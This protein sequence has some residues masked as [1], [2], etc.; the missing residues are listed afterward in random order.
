M[1]YWKH[2][3]LLAFQE[4]R[5]R[6]LLSTAVNCTRFYRDLYKNQDIEKVG[7]ENI[8]DLP[9]VSKDAIR[10]T[11]PED[12]VI[13]QTQPIKEFFTSG[14][15]GKPFAVAMDKESLSE[16]RALM[17]LR[18]MYSGW[19]IG[20]PY[21]QTGMSPER[22]SLRA[23]KDVLLRVEYQ[24]AFD[25]SSE[26]LS[27][28]AL[29]IVKKKLKYVMG[30][31]GS[32]YYLAK[33]F[34]DLDIHWPLNGVVTWGDNLS[35]HQR[36]EIEG[37]FAVRVTDT[38]GC[39]E[40]I[41]VAA[42]CKHGR[43]HTFMPHVVVE[44]VDASGNPVQPGQ[45]GRILLTRL[46]AGAMPFVRYAVGDLG[47]IETEKSCRC[48]RQG[49]AIRSINGRDTDVVKTRSGNRLIVHFFTG[50]FEYYSTIAQFRIKQESLDEIHIDL[51]PAGEFDSSILGTIEQEI[52]EKAK[53]R[54]RV[55]FKIVESISVG[56]TGKIRL[57]E[58]VLE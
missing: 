13:K 11:Y 6:M 15:S 45:I 37:R 30:F 42:Q 17:F 5:L 3:D 12:C 25:L 26:A 16:A 34:Q 9:V 7:I 46:G 55:R 40:G 1:Q 19:Q 8:S 38:Y 24:S 51:V 39:G 49:T 10:A 54:L 44:T 57:V 36:I 22:G 20:D 4:Q 33:T 2:D 47:I 53:C 43:Y 32:I 14:S 56:P 29:N 41:Q 27:E 21:L 18:A 48:G 52:Q 35:Q 31:P 28:I 23:I 50:I 58:S